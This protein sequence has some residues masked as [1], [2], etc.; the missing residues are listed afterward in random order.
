MAHDPGRHV[1]TGRQHYLKY[2]LPIVGNPTD[3]KIKSV[4]VWALEH[5]KRIAGRN[6]RRTDWGYRCEVFRGQGKMDR[7]QGVRILVVFAYDG[8]LSVE[9]SPYKF[10]HDAMRAKRDGLLS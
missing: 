6:V 4:I 5:L 3:E 1:P 7:I 2:Q 9:A 8:P 10:H